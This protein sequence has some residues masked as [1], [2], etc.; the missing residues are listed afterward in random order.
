MGPT[1]TILSSSWASIPVPYRLGPQGGC[2]GL[3]S[4]WDQGEGV[5]VYVLNR[6]N[7]SNHRALL[8]GQTFNTLEHEFLTHF[9]LFLGGCCLLEWKA[10]QL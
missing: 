10:I 3:L 2:E 4:Q 6:T 9:P 8:W 5:G 1:C 7:T